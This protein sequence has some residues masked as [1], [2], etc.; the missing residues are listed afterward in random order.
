MTNV[1]NYG[2]VQKETKMGTRPGKERNMMTTTNA[3]NYNRDC[4]DRA[5][6][7]DNGQGFIVACSYK[8]GYRNRKGNLYRK[9]A[10]I[11]KRL[12]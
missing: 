5:M 3:N 7:M 8:K 4:V 12:I 10:C 1:K 11:R 2:I 9:E 6:L